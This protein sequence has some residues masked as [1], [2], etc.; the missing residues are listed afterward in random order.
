MTDDE[1]LLISVKLD[2]LRELMELKFFEVEK[3]FD[4]VNIGIKSMH[5]RQDKT[6]GRVT[7]NDDFR[8]SLKVWGTTVVV[9]LGFLA[10]ALRE[11]MS[12]ILNSLF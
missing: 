1:R 12:D 9:F 7:K 6:N 4:S 10:P 3:E 2:H 8:N 5:D 11:A